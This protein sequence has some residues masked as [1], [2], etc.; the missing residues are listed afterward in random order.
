MTLVLQSLPVF[1]FN[2]LWLNLQ[3]NYDIYCN[4][5]KDPPSYKTYSSRIQSDSSGKQKYVCPNLGTKVVQSGFSVHISTY[6][7]STS[8]FLFFPF[9]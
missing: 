3:I 1:L 4:P 9:I 2:Q 6:L 5:F 7:L 8:V